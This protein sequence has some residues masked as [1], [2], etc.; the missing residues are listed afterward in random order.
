MQKTSF[1]VINLHLKVD[2]LLG[3]RR[4]LTI[5][6]PIKKPMKHLFKL[7]KILLPSPLMNMISS[8]ELILILLRKMEKIQRVVIM[9]MLL[10]FGNGSQRYSVG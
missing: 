7:H 1:S 2:I 9:I 8:L 5:K 10:S 3:I 6:I 4:F